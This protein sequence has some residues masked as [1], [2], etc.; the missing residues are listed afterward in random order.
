MR[1]G[2]FVFIPPKK[3]VGN[4][5][6]VSTQVS[7]QVVSK[8]WFFGGWERGKVV[9]YILRGRFLREQLGMNNK[10]NVRHK[11]M[12]LSRFRSL[13]DPKR[14]IFAVKLCTHD[15]FCCFDPVLLPT[16]VFEVLVGSE[17]DFIGR[18]MTKYVHCNSKNFGVVSLVIVS[19]EGL[20]PDRKSCLYGEWVLVI[21]C[22]CC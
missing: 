11:R 22:I 3:D 5:F 19:V 21:A 6:R 12:Y 15:A 10:K 18:I 17:L 1:V 20:L 9:K 14:G 8:A 16:N 2:M 13:L 7:I 4:V